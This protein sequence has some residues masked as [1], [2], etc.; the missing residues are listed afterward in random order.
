VGRRRRSPATSPRKPTA[1]AW[2]TRRATYG[3]CD[4]LVNNAALTY[5]I[6]LVDF[7]ASRWLNSV[8]VSLHAPIFLSQA[9]LPEMIARRAGAIVNISSGAA[10]GPGRG[11]YGNDP[12]R[13]LTLYG[14]IKAG[15][16][17]FTQGL[18]QEVYPH[19]VSVT[20][21]S[22]SVVVVTPGTIHHELVSGPD[23]PRGEPPEY[24]AEA[25]LL[26]ATEPLDRVTGWV[27]YSQLVLHEF[28]RLETPRGIGVERPGSG[29]SRI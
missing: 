17:R 26:L 24:M 12:G 9:V 10:T 19:G 3:P 20:C 23:D 1:G 15:L 6:P 22:P 11:P 25:A 8:A 27:T 14:V 5:R 7:P 2:S 21:L 16:E 18:A 28:G 13:G 29:Y 4:V